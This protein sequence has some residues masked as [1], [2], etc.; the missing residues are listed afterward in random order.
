M[1][2]KCF[3]GTGLLTCSITVCWPL[4]CLYSPAHPAH[5]FSSLEDWIQNPRAA[6]GDNQDGGWKVS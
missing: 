5:Y 6:S 1:W 2:F 3:L 4:F